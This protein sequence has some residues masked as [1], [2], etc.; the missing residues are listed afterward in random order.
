[1]AKE[2]VRSEEMGLVWD[3]VEIDS[4]MEER[5]QPSMAECRFHEMKRRAVTG[6]TNIYTNEEKQFK[7]III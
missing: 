6:S 4:R 7:Y 2:W 5:V 1:M 3:G